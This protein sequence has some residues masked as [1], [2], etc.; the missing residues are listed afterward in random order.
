MKKILIYTGLAAVVFSVACTKN[1]DKLNTDPNRASASNFNPNLLLPS[2]QLGY[3]SATTGYNG[4]ILFQSMWSQI[5]ASAIFPGYYSGGDKYVQGGSFFSYQNRTWDAG[6]QAAGYFREI[7]NLTKGNDAYTNLRGYAV[8]G[9]VLNI[10]AVT[11][12]YGDIPYSQGLQAKTGTF[13]PVYDKQQDVYKA[14]L[15]KLD[16]VLPTL[17]AAKPLPA[18]DLFSYKGDVAKWKKF[19]YS[20]MLKMAMR[21]TKAD[22]TTAQTYAVKAYTGGVFTSIDDNAYIVYNNANG[23]NNAN[24]GALTVAQ[25]YS[26]VKWGKVLIDYLKTTADPRLGVIAE[27]PQ[28]GIAN[29]AK[30]SLAGNST[31][32]AQQGMPNGYDQSAGTT[33]ISNAP[34]Y[35][36][37]SGTGSDVNPTGNY[38]RPKTSLYLSLSAPA[39]ILTYGQTELLLAE[40]A[41]R[42]WAVGASA[43]VHYANGLS[44]ALQTY[45]QINAVGAISAATATAYAAANPLDISSTANSLKQI[46]TQYWVLTGTIFDFSE[47]WSNWRRSGYPVLTPVNYTGNFTV[48]TI[49][50]RQAYPT[51]EISNNPANYAAAVTGITGGDVYNARVWWDK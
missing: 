27:V 45:G 12:T 37:A 17:S 29:A 42:G 7:Q 26:E 32:A 49:P 24:S 44:A 6:Y 34:G 10:Q 9:E 18:N 28:P 40:A 43:S 13:Q 38:S 39:F 33:N 2:G 14:M 8:I 21:L 23:F 1:F 19:G 48:G 5:F 25:D 46:N 47:A 30:Q 4:P 31:P 3:L 41:A 20:L 11:D 15:A 36:G 22:A 35:P 16:S 50:R 51:G